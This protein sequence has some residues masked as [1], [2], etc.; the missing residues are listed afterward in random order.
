MVESDSYL[1]GRAR[2]YILNN[3]VPFIDFFRETIFGFVQTEKNRGLYVRIHLKDDDIVEADCNCRDA[4]NG[5]ICEHMLVLYELGKNWPF[6]ERWIHRDF[7]TYPLSRLF[8]S[9][10]PKTLR[11]KLSPDSNPCLD[12]TDIE[13]FP[14]IAAYLFKNE[15]PLAKRDGKALDSAIRFERSPGEVKMISK[16]VPSKK[17]LYEGS[18]LF[19]VAKFAFLLHQKD[20]LDMDLEWMKNHRVKLI[21][22]LSGAPF[23]VWTLNISAFLSGAQLDMGFWSNYLDIKHN[24]I[25]L[26]LDYRI[27]FSQS[28]DLRIEPGVGQ[29]KFIPIANLEKID[30]YYFHEDL[31]YFQTQ[32]GLSEFELTYS[33][34]P[35]F[36]IYKKKIPAFLKRYRI[37]LN[38]LD[39][40]NID[41]SLYG[42]VLLNLVD[43][44]FMVL[45]DFSNSVFHLRLHIQLGDDRYTISELRNLIT[46]ELPNRY[47]NLRNRFFDSHT[48]DGELIRMLLSH[49]SGSRLPVQ[50]IFQLILHFH[51]RIHVETNDLT[52]DA[53]KRLKLMQMEKTPSLSQTHLNLRPYQDLGYQWLWFLRSYGLGGLLCDQMGL[54]KTHQGM[55][56]LAAVKQQQ[57]TLSA[58][59]I[60]PR[61]VLFHWE[62]K[63]ETFCPNITVSMFYGTKRKEKEALNSE[64]VL[65]SYGTLRAQAAQF[66]NHRFDVILFDEIQ[67]AKNKQTLTFQSLQSL[68]AGCRIGLTGTPV[69]NKLKELKSLMDIVLPGYLGSDSIFRYAYE[70]PITKFR[71]KTALTQLKKSIQP[72]TLR[73][74]KAE[75]LTD[76]PEKIEDI[77]SFDLSPVEMDLY[78]KIKEEGKDGLY[79]D[80][81]VKPLHVFHLINRLKQ[82]CCH[83]VLYFKHTNYSEYPSQKWEV[84]KSILHETLSMGEKIVVFTQYLG[85]IDIF[86]KYLE[87]HQIGYASITGSVVKRQEEQNRFQNNPA[88]KVFIGTIGAAGVGIDLTAAS[89]LVHYDR[90]WNPAREEQATDRIHRIGQEKS[91]QI[92]KFIARDTIEERIDKLIQM[93]KELLKDIIGFDPDHTLKQLTVEELLEVLA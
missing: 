58:L 71:N 60:A 69:E 52:V 10:S 20:A 53:F 15:S 1:S 45:E 46:N 21:L 5:M 63:L 72:F 16:G 4:N 91:V 12:L 36:T 93:K 85:M 9:M 76:L 39:R 83:P 57:K 89:V 6:E 42:K 79:K 56:L 38:K 28:G 74:S 50:S 64:V 80:G 87:H 44:V 11:S 17:C 35:E 82:F 48:M 67:N 68:H 61:S 75:V 90:W 77:R 26:P 78:H 29:E 27:C 54:G 3:R 73:R 47:W 24:P 40:T 23:F 43:G 33:S 18:S 32:T 41:S 49:E 88:C 8:Q 14:R 22:R 51:N 66:T 30:R 55:A 7:M 70:V 31:G 84:F 19:R 65:T 34:K 25:A 13:E 37:D 81:H 62:E 59:V 92:F 86:K 2:V